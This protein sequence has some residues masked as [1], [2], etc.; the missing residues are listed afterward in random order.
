MTRRTSRNLLRS[1]CCA[2]SLVLTLPVHAQ[3]QIGI[4]AALAIGSSGVV[5]SVGQ[6]PAARVAAAQIT[7]DQFIQ[8]DPQARRER[9]GRLN[10]ENK[11]L[12]KRTHAERWLVRNRARLSEAQSPCRRKRSSSSPLR[13]I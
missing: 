13:Y 4:V 6:Q 2:A 1:C 5:T 7:Y 10:A 3:Q 9:F 11:A 8:L 12:I